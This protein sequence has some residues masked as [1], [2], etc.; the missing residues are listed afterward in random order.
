LLDQLQVQNA[1]AAGSLD[2]ESDCNGA[3]GAQSNDLTWVRSFQGRRLLGR[4]RN[5]LDD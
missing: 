1:V 3:G 5:L 4:P 2:P